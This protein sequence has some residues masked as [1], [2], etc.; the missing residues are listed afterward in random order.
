MS[1]K[2]TFKRLIGVGAFACCSAILLSVTAQSARSQQI[3]SVSDLGGMIGGTL[4]FYQSLNDANEPEAAESVIPEALYTDK[5]AAEDPASEEAPA[6]DA[7]RSLPDFTEDGDLEFIPLTTTVPADRASTAADAADTSGAADT[8]DTADT[9]DSA[10]NDWMEDGDSGRES[11]NTAAEKEDK[12]SKENKEDKAPVPGTVTETGTADAGK[13][14]ADPTGTETAEESAD[15]KDADWMETVET[16][17]GGEEL[18]AAASVTLTLSV[19]NKNHT[20]YL[21]GYE[22]GTA[23]PGGKITRAEAC[24]ILYNLLKSRPKERAVLSDVKDGAWYAE[25]VR[26]LAACGIVDCPGDKARPDDYMTRAELVSALTRL[27]QSN[28]TGKNTFSDVTPSHPYYAAIIKAVGLGWV[29]GY[30]D[31]TFKP[32]G[33]ITRAEAAK[34]VNR[35]LNR[36]PDKD[37]IDANIT[38]SLYSD[39]TPDHWA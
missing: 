39:L 8:P 3:P 2:N 10:E 5:A 34:V 6:E 9:P 37:W 14:D 27:V 21:H 36:N 26:L 30:E 31:G 13:T 33:S 12:D 25:P 16:E 20:E 28:G 24:Q 11:D 29:N 4:R 15:G 18:T 38:E 35:A 23:R 19:D 1:N 17:D 32:D 7:D 22:D